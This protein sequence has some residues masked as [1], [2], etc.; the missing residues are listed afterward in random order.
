MDAVRIDAT[1]PQSAVDRQARTIQMMALGLALG[2]LF[3]VSFLIF[4][5]LYNLLTVRWS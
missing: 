4:G 3:A 2:L 1:E 5:P